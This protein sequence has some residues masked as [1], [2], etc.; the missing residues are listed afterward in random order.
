MQT[1]RN[2]LKK[3]WICR[4]PLFGRYFFNIQSVQLQMWCWQCRSQSCVLHG[5][6]SVW[7][8]L[9]QFKTMYLNIREG[10]REKRWV[11]LNWPLRNSFRVFEKQN[12]EALHII[13]QCM[14]LQSTSGGITPH[15]R[16]NQKVWQSSVGYQNIN[17]ISPLILTIVLRK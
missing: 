3:I 9:I 1:V 14:T 17:L 8:C 4:R 11:L 16:T 10:W 6:H 7:E 12:L 2:K 5:P 15:R 13:P